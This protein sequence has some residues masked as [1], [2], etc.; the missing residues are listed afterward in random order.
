[1]II[2]Y[3][4]KTGKH[5]LIYG[6]GNVIS[7]MIG[8]IL[9]PLYTRVLSTEEYGILSLMV[10]SL[11]ISTIILTMGLQAALFRF[12][13]YDYSKKNQRIELVSTVIIFITFVSLILSS[14]L[15][16]FSD[17]ISELFF[18]TASYSYYLKIM[19]IAS[20]FETGNIIQ[21]PCKYDELQSIKDAIKSG[22][23]EEYLTDKE[24]KMLK[25]EFDLGKQI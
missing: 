20:F 12:Y 10:V 22:I 17:Q 18:N 13:I 6:L 23:S 9:I 14:L 24:K 11:T 8:F 25:H 2:N 16:Y 19:F 3:L 5:Y 4:K 7:K 21:Q 15:F 1:M